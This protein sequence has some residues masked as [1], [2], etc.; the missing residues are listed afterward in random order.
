[1]PVD[2]QQFFVMLAQSAQHRRPVAQSLL[3]L[4][5]LRLQDRL[6]PGDSAD[7]H[8]QCLQVNKP[9]FAPSKARRVPEERQQHRTTYR[10]SDGGVSGSPAHSVA[11]SSRRISE[12]WRGK[13]ETGTST[14][15]RRPRARDPRESEM[16]EEERWLFRKSDGH[17]NTLSNARVKQCPF[18]SKLVWTTWN[19]VLVSSLNGCACRRKTN[20]AVMHA[21]QSPR[22][23]PHDII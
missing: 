1:L 18:L 14:Q 11:P 17:F 8:L 3:R 7:V 23:I 9:L 13:E 15:Q 12:S 22:R 10:L 2:V 6:L 5:Q 21:S 19:G 4:A 20:S 16:A